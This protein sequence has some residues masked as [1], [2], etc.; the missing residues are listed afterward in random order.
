VSDAPLDGAQLLRDGLVQFPVVIG[1]IV[2][3]VN[4]DGITAGQLRFT[5]PLLADI[6]LGKVTNWSHPSIAAVNPG[7]ELPDLA[8]LVIHRSDGSGTT[9]NWADYLSKV[10]GEWKVR[11]GA[12]TLV[13]WP[14]GV[15]G[16]GNNG[17]ADYV[18]RVRGAI[19]YV[20]YGS[21]QRKKMAYALVQ[22]KAGNFVLPDT[23]SFQAA[24][25]DLDWTKVRE[26][27][28]SLTDSPKADAYPIMAA[29]FALIR[30]YPKDVGRSHNVLAF[31][32]WALESGQVMAT[33][34]DYL[35]LPPLLVQEVETYWK[36]ELDPGTNEPSLTRDVSRAPG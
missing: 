16:K 7:I 22:N 23:A 2:P 5:G 25:A 21:A 10:S 24:T 9:H 3:V 28:V 14:T 15:G 17:V 30:K 19:G 29:S 8:I 1:A 31:F 36:A 11:V 34:L 20:E 26:A 27:T 12:S 13:G 33:A 32:R 35:P 4:L 18:T 6:F